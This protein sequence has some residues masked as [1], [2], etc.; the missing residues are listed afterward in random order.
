[1]GDI[2]QQLFEGELKLNFRDIEEMPEYQAARRAVREAEEPFYAKL[3]R[4]QQTT[5]ESLMQQSLAAEYILTVE[6]FRRGFSTAVQL[7][8]ASMAR[9]PEEPRKK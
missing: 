4:E 3:T 9:R 8:A 6:A 7:L 1:M 2:L 5:Y